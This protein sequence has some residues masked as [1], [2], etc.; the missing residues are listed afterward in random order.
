MLLAVFFRGPNSR[1]DVLIGISTII[2]GIFLVGDGHIVGPIILALAG[3]LLWLY[4]AP[5][6]SP[7]YAF[8]LRIVYIAL[9]FFAGMLIVG[10]SPS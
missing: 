1:L 6:N 9:V 10:P 2:V 5:Q 4:T 3:L 8:A 7:L